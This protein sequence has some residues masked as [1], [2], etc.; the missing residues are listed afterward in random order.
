[1]GKKDRNHTTYRDITSG[2]V[3]ER[4]YLDSRNSHISSRTDFGESQTHGDKGTSKNNKTYSGQMDQTKNIRRDWS[5]E[6]G[7][8][9]K[10][11]REQK[12]H[13]G[14]GMETTRQDMDSESASM[15]EEK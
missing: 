11:K 1:M 3:V 14:R 10:Q 12:I 15:V 8:I 9:G 2:W 13:C 4:R 6:S 5:G 7:Q